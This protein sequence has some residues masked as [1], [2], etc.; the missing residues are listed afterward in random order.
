MSTVTIKDLA[1]E[2]GVSKQAVYSRIT[3]DPLRTI[4][5]GVDNAVQTN[6]QGT[7]LL[8]DAGAAII[9]NAYA[10]KYQQ[11]TSLATAAGYGRTVSPRQD[12]SKLDNLLSQ[13]G[14][15]NLA[16]ARM[17][18]DS[19]RNIQ[20]IDAL[21]QQ[22]KTLESQRNANAEPDIIG[23]ITDLDDIEADTNSKVLELE[24]NLS[25][26]RAT[27]KRR[28]ARLL[29]AEGKVAEL[30]KE[31][32]E[33]NAQNS[34]LGTVREELKLIAARLEDKEAKLIEVEKRFV[35]AKRKAQS[36]D[37]KLTDR[38]AK[39]A[40]LEVEMAN[41]KLATTEHLADVDA[42]LSRANSKAEEMEAAVESGQKK[43]TQLEENLV[44]ASNNAQNQDVR[45]GDLEKELAVASDGLTEKDATIAE[46]NSRMTE[47]DA[48]ISELEQL[49]ASTKSETAAI[50]SNDAKVHELETALK[51]ARDRSD[52]MG[53]SLAEA[54][55]QLRDAKTQLSE[56]DALILELEGKIAPPSQNSV[57]EDQST[58]EPATPI[59]PVEP[60]AQHT[61]PP[62][63]MPTQ[64]EVASSAATPARVPRA[65]SRPHGELTL[66]ERV[67]RAR[68]LATNDNT[69][70]P[71]VATRIIDAMKV[72][73]D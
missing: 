62:P 65:D 55:N 49:L 4:L 1:N 25:E 7:I 63:L 35:E 12:D 3:K 22:V 51:E 45:I 20:K 72:L 44:Q 16:M 15:M 68:G 43:V 33:A 58:S 67:Q 28:S 66:A 32:T 37:N 36:L 2:L 9:R 18:Q 6:T 64:L 53:S 40:E 30:E 29:E 52:S 23:R 17:L 70:K 60:P 47:K 46:L 14:D 61:A 42:K 11:H 71:G 48:T 31:L 41:A 10:E 19:S 8:S 24:Q 73:E 34:E 26:A 21:Q 50:A 56:K 5:A 69:Q 57:E 27:M 39:L 38:E 13:I 59:A 54:D